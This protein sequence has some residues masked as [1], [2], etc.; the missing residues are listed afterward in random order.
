MYPLRF[1]QFDSDFRTYLALLGMADVVTV[2]QHPDQ[3]LAAIPPY[4]RPVLPLSVYSLKFLNL[5][6]SHPLYE[7]PTRNPRETSRQSF[8][9]F[10]VGVEDLQ[11]RQRL[12]EV[13]VTFANGTLWSSLLKSWLRSGT[14]RSWAASEADA[15]DDQTYEK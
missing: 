10:Q 12:T 5:V 8:G 4:P 11:R 1:F 14:H 9:R 3:L 2:R 13:L 6:C 7:E 15:S